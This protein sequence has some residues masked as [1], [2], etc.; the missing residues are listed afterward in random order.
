[1][2]KA[3]WLD[4]LHRFT[5]EF[6][7]TQLTTNVKIA[8]I[9]RGSFHSTLGSILTLFVVVQLRS[10]QIHSCIPTT[11]NTGGF[12]IRNYFIKCTF[13]TQPHFFITCKRV[14]ISPLCFLATK[15]KKCGQKAVSKRG[16]L[17]KNCQTKGESRQ[18][19]RLLNSPD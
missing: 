15:T 3:L 6:V 8:R 12:K 5:E 18:K 4:K 16:G 11:Q 9:F 10:V 13:K 7:K 17:T 14:G 2:V 1:M 19:A